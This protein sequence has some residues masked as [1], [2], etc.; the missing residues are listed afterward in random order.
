MMDEERKE[1]L[2]RYLREAKAKSK[3]KSFID[4]AERI[5]LEQDFRSMLNTL[6]A[7][8]I[9]TQE[10]F[11]SLLPEREKH[12]YIADFI[13]WKDDVRIPIFLIASPNGKLIV[14]RDQL[15]DFLTF[16]KR[17]DHNEAVLVWMLTPNFPSKV[18]T[19]EEIEEKV[20]SEE[21][22]FYFEML[23][24]FK[25]T[26]L[27]LFNEKAPVWSISRPA[28]ME[29]VGGV[30]RFYHTFNETFR[31][32][33]ERE[34]KRRRPR[35]SHKRRALSTISDEDIETICN[36]IKMYLMDQV[37]IKDVVRTIEKRTI[38]KTK[39]LK[40]EEYD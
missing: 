8:G 18:L 23:I 30:E 39:N 29:E 36:A 34:M 25:E 15:H 22:Y 13:M 12:E 37:D 40:W 19:I 4:L 28:E 9:F 5:T 21:D 35:L 26:I 31:E 20:K 38:V 2:S 11:P 7:K 16:L 6:K 32:K 1:L 17:T 14:L 33:F 27:G 10:I 24:P 3:S